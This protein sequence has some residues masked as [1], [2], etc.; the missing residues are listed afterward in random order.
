MIVIVEH[1]ANGLPV[2]PVTLPH[3]PCYNSILG[4][5][6][7]HCLLFA[8]AALGAVLAAG[9]GRAQA[10]DPLCARY[11]GVSLGTMRG[12]PVRHDCAGI[13]ALA[14]DI[15]T[16]LMSQ[17]AALSEVLDGIA[18]Q[19][20][21]RPIARLI[22]EGDPNLARRCQARE[23]E[24]LRYITCALSPTI[25]LYFPL[26]GDGKAR[27]IDADFNLEA[28][29]RQKLAGLTQISPIAYQLFADAV[30]EANQKNAK[31]LPLTVKGNLLMLRMPL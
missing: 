10:S 31:P 4:G 20:R 5:S 23:M 16:G 17:F 24:Q 19:A 12:Q 25:T 21:S 28:H 18:A 14:A 30:A 15:G 7:R 22:A 29:V 8:F 9:D 13:K 1:S 3:W 2:T 26:A 11:A 27:S 6:V